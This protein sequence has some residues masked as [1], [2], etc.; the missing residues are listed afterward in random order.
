MECIDFLTISKLNTKEEKERFLEIKRS[1]ITEAIAFPV[2]TN[3]RGYLY[4]TTPKA[5]EERFRRRSGFAAS[6][7][8]S[9]T[10]QKKGII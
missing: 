10:K 7:A 5:K 9:L 1:L 2:G 4:L 6:Q 3:R 8:D